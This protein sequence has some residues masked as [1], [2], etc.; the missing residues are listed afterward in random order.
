MARFGRRQFGLGVGAALIA[1]PFL[2][3]VERTVR[4]DDTKSAKRL[5]VF[6]TPNGTIHD[7]WRPTGSGA[8]FDFPAG[9]ILEPLAPHKSDLIICDGLDFKGFDNHEAGM[10]AMLTGGGGAGTESAGMSIDQYVAGKIGEA[11]RFPSLEFGVQTSAWGGNVQ[12]RMSY[13]GPGLYVPPDDS[14]KSAFERM[15]GDIGQDDAAAARAMLRRQSVIDLV[16]GELGTLQK[17]VGAEERQKLEK[18]LDAIRKVETG[19]QGSGS[20][21]APLSPLD[22]DP[23]A[24]DSFPAIGRAQT[25]LLV[26]ALACGMTRVGSLQWSHTVGPTVFSWLGQ[27][28]GHHSLSHSDS[29]NAAGVAAFVAA[30]RWFAGEFAYL[31]E[32]LK[33]RPDPEGGGTMLDTTVVVWAKELGDGRAHTC[34]DVP[35]IL[36]GN[37]GGRWNTGRYLTFDGAPHQKLLVSICHAM[38]LTNPTFGDPSNG[39]GPLDGLT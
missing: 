5:I 35:F 29:S 1:A 25:D 18:H 4:A 39:T 31:L 9:S 7:H 21:E 38:G 20:C 17:R 24:N 14:P 28:E 3:L 23:Y 36:A 26:T 16:R 27:T 10:G 37:A 13:G 22:L 19:L 30:E 32:Q 2:G 11:S 12:T 33:S 6:F 34:Q 15:F 8:N